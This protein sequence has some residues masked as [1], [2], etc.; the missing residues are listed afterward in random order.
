MPRRDAGDEP[1]PLGYRIAE[2][3]VPGV[4]PKYQVLHGSGRAQ[5]FIGMRDS[6]DEAAQLAHQH[7]SRA[8]AE[9]AAR[10]NIVGPRPPT[11]GRGVGR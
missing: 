7:H 9:R 6:R 10:A 11:P 4:P 8:E 5:Q 2:S 3:G 1:L